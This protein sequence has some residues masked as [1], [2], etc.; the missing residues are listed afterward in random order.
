MDIKKVIEIVRETDKIFFDDELRGDV[1]EKGKYDYVTAADTGI[2]E[3]LHRRLKE[4][5]PETGFKSEE[6]KTFEN[7]RDYWILDPIDGT[8]NFMHQINQCAVSL[9]LCSDGELEAGIVY[10][11]YTKELFWAEKGKGAFLN[12]IAINCS[13]H[14]KLSDCLGAIELNAYFKNECDQALEQAKK[15]YLRCQDVRVIGCA[16]VGLCYV[17]CG[18]LDVFLGRRLKPWD[19]AAGYVIVNEAGGNVT[20]PDGKVDAGILNQH[21]V[22]TNGLVHNEFLSLI[23]E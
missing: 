18:K 22:A 9:G 13:K 20:T 4:E 19:F 11:P 12:G 14:D 10:V 5:F 16:A 21:I 6:E 1:R 23:N 7:C 8:T 17:A 15:I 3:Y 2:S